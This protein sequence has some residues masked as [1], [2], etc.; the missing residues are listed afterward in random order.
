MGEFTS[1]AEYPELVQTL[2]QGVR[3]TGWISGTK[4]LKANPYPTP[5]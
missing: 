3:Y 1:D 5:Y 4:G 2:D